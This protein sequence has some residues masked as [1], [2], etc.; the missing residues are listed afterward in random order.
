MLRLLALAILVGV[1]AQPATAQQPVPGK[2][3]K[4]GFSQIVDHPALNA[5]RQGFID[6]LAA[7]GFVVGRNL[8]LDYQNAQGD[9]GNARNIAQKFLTE[10]VDLLAPCTTPNV[11]ATIQL[12][13]GGKTPVVFGCVTNPVEAGVVPAVDKPTGT[14]VTGYYSIP[15]VGRSL[16]LFLQIKPGMKTVGTLYN[17]S[18]T[19]S[20][21]LKR[22]AKAE[23]EKR[24]LTWVEATVASSAEVKTAIDTLVTKV[25]AVLTAQDNTV[26]SAYEAVVKATRDAKKPLFALDVSV[27]ERGA[28]AALAQNQYEAGKGWAKELAIPV[29]L[30]KDPGTLKPVEASVYDLQVN[31]AAAKEAGVTVPEAAVARAVKVFGR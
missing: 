15:P 31:L 30:G 17:A 7:A 21:N 2:T 28:I 29:L 20:I 4:I 9:V 22:I 3:Y 19:N 26:S 24:G 18:E 16:E 8:V 5:T 6:E 10:S 23:A 12:A 27:V 25:D 13:K 14:N 11:M 1:L